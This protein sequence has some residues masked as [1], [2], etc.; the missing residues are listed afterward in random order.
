MTYNDSFYWLA[1]VWTASS[2]IMLESTSVAHFELCSRHRLEIYATTHWPIRK[3][4]Y[5]YRCRPTSSL[6]GP[7]TCCCSRQMFIWRLTDRQLQKMPRADGSK[8]LSRNDF[9][10]RPRP[11]SPVIE[12]LCNIVCVHWRCKQLAS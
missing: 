6:D 1:Y 11:S 9:N 5:W 4:P 3:Q 8:T 10:H 7:S 2:C 12:I